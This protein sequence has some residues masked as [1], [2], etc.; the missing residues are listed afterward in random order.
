M[1]SPFTITQ[2]ILAHRLANS[3]TPEDDTALVAVF[4]DANPSYLVTRPDGESEAVPYIHDS[5]FALFLQQ[6]TAKAMAE[7]L[8]TK[9]EVSL[10][11]VGGSSN[12]AKQI[13]SEI[14]SKVRAI[15]LYGIPPITTTIRTSPAQEESGEVAPKSQEAPE[16]KDAPDVA[17]KAPMAEEPPAEAPIHKGEWKLVPEV[18][19]VL[20]MPAAADRRKVDPAAHFENLHSLLNKLVQ[21][22]GIDPADLDKQLGMSPGFT[23]SLCDDLKRDNTPKKIV[24]QYLDYFDLT[25]YLYLFKGQCSEVAKELAD[26]PH[27]DSYRVKQARNTTEERF[28]LLSVKTGTD[29]NGAYLYRLTLQSP[30]RKQDVIVSS[31]FNFVVDREYEIEGLSPLGDSAV[32]NK[33]AIKGAETTAAALV[34]TE[35]QEAEV[36]AKIEEEM[37]KRGKPQQQRQQQLQKKTDSRMSGKN[38]YMEETPEEQFEREK[39]IVLEYIIRTAGCSPRDAQKKFEPLSDFPDIVS[40]FAKYIKTKKPGSC[41]SRGYNAA[42][43]MNKLH[44]GPYDAYVMLAGLERDPKKTQEVLKYRETDPQYQKPEKPPAKGKE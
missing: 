4:L 44:Y 16:A 9:Q 35:E 31:S 41:S 6:E 28:K 32:A 19:Q 18:K 30:H 25:A 1:D 20:S 21:V 43:L 15:K 27:V 13:L 24:I 33:S 12:G 14:T 7:K 26:N 34:S 36:L 23:K 42:R 17:S 10:G 5:M 29:S 40:D 22:N 39:N 2:K 3:N 37:K 11:V 38:R 8:S